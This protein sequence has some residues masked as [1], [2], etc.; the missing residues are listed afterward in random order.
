MCTKWTTYF[1]QPIVFDSGLNWTSRQLHAVIQITE[2]DY[3]VGLLHNVAQSARNP[4]VLVIWDLRCT[5][6]GECWCWLCEYRVTYVSTLSIASLH[7]GLVSCNQKHSQII[8]SRFQSQITNGMSP[9]WNMDLYN[10]ELNLAAA[11]WPKSFNIHKYMVRDINHM[12]E[13][14]TSQMRSDEEQWLVVEL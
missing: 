11:T 5:K 14:L 2:P 8:I 1:L 7:V 12:C 4:T 9:P 13:R 6:T 10:L 3:H